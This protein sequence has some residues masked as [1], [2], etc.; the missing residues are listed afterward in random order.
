MAGRQ[1]AVIQI[2]SCTAACSSAH[3][4]ILIGKISWDK[5]QESCRLSDGSL[6]AQNSRATAEGKKPY[7]M[8]ECCSMSQL[9]IEGSWDIWDKSS[10]KVENVIFAKS[11][12]LISNTDY[13]WHWLCPILCAFAKKIQKKEQN[14]TDE[15]TVDLTAPQ[16]CLV[17][18]EGIKRLQDVAMEGILE[19]TFFFSLQWCSKS[20]QLLFQRWTRREVQEERAACLLDM[21][22]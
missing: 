6:I 1:A 12:A 21:P 3:R 7:S 19:G 17:H 13:M 10:W 4:L 15:S 18:W 22:K 20:A 11:A 14:S 9:H 2:I 8:H 16:C 5:L